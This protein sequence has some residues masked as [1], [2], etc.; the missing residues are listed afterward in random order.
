[1]LLDLSEIE[2]KLYEKFSPFGGEMDDLIMKAGGGSIDDVIDLEKKLNVKLHDKFKN[3][4]LKYDLGNFSLGSFIFGDDGDY[5]GKIFELNSENDFTQW[6]GKGARPENLL[7][8][9]Y[10]D[11]YSILLDLN[12][13]KV[14]AITSETDLN[15]MKHISSDFFLFCRGVST[16]FLNKPNPIDVEKLVGSENKFFWPS[17]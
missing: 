2:S 15:E 14:Y 10:N 17:L 5:L 3:F 6:W 4:V 11:P 13:G 1:M 9:T 8:V 12:S 16:M 7:L